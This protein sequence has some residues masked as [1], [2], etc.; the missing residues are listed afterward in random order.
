MNHKI[1]QV[2]SAVLLVVALLTGQQTWAAND[3][4]DEW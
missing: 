1:N 4:D 3:W 2:L